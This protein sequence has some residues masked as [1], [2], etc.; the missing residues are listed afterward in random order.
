MEL[1]YL[2]ILLIIGAAVVGWFLSY[3]KSRFELRAYK[4][5]IKEYKEHLNRQMKI[6]SEGSK[7]L[8]NELTTLKKENEN[9]RIS[10]QSL[11]QKP[12]R[13]ELRLL[14]IYDGALRKMMLKAPGF[15]S[16][17]EMS[18][19]ETEREYEEN[20]KGFKSII[21]K[22]FGPSL[23]HQ[24]EHTHKDIGEHTSDFEVK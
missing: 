5:E 14:N 2:G 13:A 3:I 10:V 19:Q 17:W 6:T 15:S 7:N 8:E 18:L 11:G 4:K 16:A 20:E 22:V 1:S 12:G 23:T 24:P 21:K 9:L